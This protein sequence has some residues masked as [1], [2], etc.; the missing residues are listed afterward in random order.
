MDEDDPGMK[1]SGKDA[2]PSHQLESTGFPAFGVSNQSPEQELEGHHCL[3]IARGGSRNGMSS[4]PQKTPFHSPNISS[5][6][7]HALYPDP[8]A[9]VIS[10]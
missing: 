2:N 1:E 3:S 5:F 9:P 4:V 7:S 8:A 6:S 10:R